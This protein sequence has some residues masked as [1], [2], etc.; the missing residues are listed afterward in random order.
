MLFRRVGCN[1]AGFRGRLLAIRFDDD[2]FE[3]GDAAEAGEKSGGGLFVRLGGPFQGT[4][5][6][7]FYFTFAYRV[8][9]VH[10]MFSLAKADFDF[11]EA[12]FEIDPQGDKCQAFFL[13]TDRQPQDLAFVQ[14]QPAP[15]FR[16]VVVNIALF[17]GIDM[18]AD[19]VNLAVF[20]VAVTVLERNMP[21][22]QRLDFR[23]PQFDAGLDAIKDMIIVMRPPVYG[24]DFLAHSGTR[25]FRD[26]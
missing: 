24:Y 7:P 3:I 5:E 19:Q 2:D 6:F 15:P 20:H 16:I 10:G 18:H 12:V 23:A 8:A 22:A 17:I 14:Q 11:G 25:S 4:V 13:D 26:P 21:V 1:E 9:F